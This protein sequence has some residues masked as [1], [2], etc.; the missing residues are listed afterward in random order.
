M[1]LESL[2]DWKKRATITFP[3]ASATS[4]FG[5][6]DGGESAPSEN[7]GFEKSTPVSMIPI[8][9]PAPAWPSPP[10]ADQKTGAPMTGFDASRVGKYSR[11]GCTAAT[12]G[13]FARS[14]TDPAG[15]A[16][17]KPLKTVR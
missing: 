13:I 12:P 17:A 3:F 1:S 10:S 9:I 11:T 14:A 6:P 2:T 16:R 5:K 15:T 7:I 4:P 8:F